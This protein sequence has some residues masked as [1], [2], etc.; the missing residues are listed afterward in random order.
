LI[1]RSNN[2]RAR[3]AGTVPR[4]AGGTGAGVFPACGRAGRVPER[5]RVFA[6]GRDRRTRGSCCRVR[7]R[8][9]TRFHISAERGRTRGLYSCRF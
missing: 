4:R 5:R 6:R 2:T 9:G 7:I 8:R 3:A 1:D